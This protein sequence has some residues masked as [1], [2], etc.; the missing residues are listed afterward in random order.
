MTSALPSIVITW[1]TQP[2]RQAMARRV[3]LRTGEATPEQLDRILKYRNPASLE[4]LVFGG[5]PRMLGNASPEAI[6]KMKDETF[7]LKKNKEKVALGEA[8]LPSGPGQPLLLRFPRESGGKPVVTVEDKEIELVTR[9]GGS[10]IRTKFKLADM[11]VD[12][13]LEI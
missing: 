9:F 5:S 13:R 10:T 4:F 2:V 1:Y 12:G 11:V 6:Q 3:Q 7:L 8:A